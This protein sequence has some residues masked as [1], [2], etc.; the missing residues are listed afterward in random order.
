MTTIN[1]QNA[2]L[3][4]IANALVYNNR[5]KNVKLNAT[6]IGAE[7]LAQW[8]TVCTNLC[9]SAYNL[10][11]YCEDN[12]LKTHDAPNDLRKPVWDA[13]AALLDACDKVNEHRL[14][15]TD[16]FINLVLG[17]SGK[18]ADNDSAELRACKEDIRK[19]Q[20]SI[21]TLKDM[22][23]VNPDHVAELE[24]QLADLK[25][26]RTELY[27]TAD[28][29]IKKPTMVNPEA[30]RLDVEHLIARA[31]ECQLA[32]TLDELDKEVAE[33]KAAAKAAAKARKAAKKANA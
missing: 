6:Q 27:A 18:R 25:D 13:S 12:A 16:D 21:S 9:R 24:A 17:Y 20:K 7:T 26:K 14:Y 1:T 33:R 8:K 29:C 30:F 28:M 15:I 32:K 3:N 23:G 10:Y 22:N 2:T 31:I 5:F 19:L 4:S 11:A